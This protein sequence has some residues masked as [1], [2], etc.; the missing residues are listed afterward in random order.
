MDSAPS[1]RSNFRRHPRL[2][3]RREVI[4]LS[5]NGRLCMRTFGLAGAGA[6]ASGRLLALAGTLAVLGGTGC[7][8]SSLA[9]CVG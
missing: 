9:A 6:E 8:A 1:S 4:Q 2:L 7:T 5:E 3:D